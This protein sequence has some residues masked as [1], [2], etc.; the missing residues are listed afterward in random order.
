MLLLQVVSANRCILSTHV[1][2]DCTH[3]L[4]GE[5]PVQHGLLCKYRV[6]VHEE[7]YTRYTCGIH[8]V[9]KVYMVYK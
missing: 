2:D 1:S 9:H 4:E 3:A 8:M 7:W 6:A 5:K